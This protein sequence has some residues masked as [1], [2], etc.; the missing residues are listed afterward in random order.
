M[1]YAASSET[2]TTDRIEI[3][4]TVSGMQESISAI[5]ESSQQLITL[6]QRLSAKE[7]FNREDQE[8]IAQLATALNNNA[9]AINNIAKALP[10]Q[11][12][13]AQGRINILLDRVVHD[14]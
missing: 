12:E 5:N 13:S 4:I 6:T 14:L 3:I 11:F 9:D 10:Q 7:G 1:L 2:N 8:V